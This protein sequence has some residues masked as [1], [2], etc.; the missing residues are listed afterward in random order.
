[1]AGTCLSGTEH[2]TTLEVGVRTE[3][4][5]LGGEQVAERKRAGL[6]FL[7]QFT[8]WD[9]LVKCRWGNGKEQTVR[10]RRR[11]QHNIKKDL[12]KTVGRVDWID[13]AQHWGKWLSCCEE[14]I[15]H[16]RPRECGGLSTLADGR[17]ADQEGLWH[18]SLSVSA[19]V[20]CLFAATKC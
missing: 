17:A 10:P 18:T 4:F 19:A 11:W 13:V 8:G 20:S 16:V 6:L 14:G 15:E 9:G 2:S 3:D 7:G 12:K 5:R 1:M